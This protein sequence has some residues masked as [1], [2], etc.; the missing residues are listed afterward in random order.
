MYIECMRRPITN[1]YRAYL[2]IWFEQIVH[3]HKDSTQD[4]VEQAMSQR[5][6][7]HHHCLDAWLGGVWLI[8]QMIVVEM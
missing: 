5:N 3:W 7:P 1:L 2:L 4:R 8:K 6:H